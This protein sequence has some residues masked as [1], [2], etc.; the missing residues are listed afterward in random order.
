MAVRD[1][2]AGIQQLGA[3]LAEAKVAPIRSKARFAE[4]NFWQEQGIRQEIAKEDRVQKKVIERLK[5]AETIR[6]DREEANRLRTKREGLFSQ[7]E[8][9]ISNVRSL[10]VSNPDRFAD[11]ALTRVDQRRADIV[12]RG[13]D[14]TARIESRTPLL[15]DD[16]LDVMDELELE[17]AQ[18]RKKKEK[19]AAESAELTRDIKKKTL[20]SKGKPPK[21]KEASIRFIGSDKNPRTASIGDLTA[22]VVAAEKKEIKL[23]ASDKWA[24]TEGRKI[25]NES[26]S[27]K[28]EEKGGVLDL[29][30]GVVLGGD[31]INLG[32]ED[33]TLF[34]QLLEGTK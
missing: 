10:I 20:A 2:V 19:V 8:S 25:L 11:D 5:V 28:H 12:R 16:I 32:K 3:G 29:T 18:A 14:S 21:V 15:D 17:G 6:Q 4:Q 27:Q 34:N 30:G 1:I 26:L 22:E 33:E 23:T 31:N 13:E 24:R 9:R 7:A